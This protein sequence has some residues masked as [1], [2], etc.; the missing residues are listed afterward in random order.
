[1]ERKV[2]WSCRLPSGCSVR[3]TA[4]I[5]RADEDESCILTRFA[6]VGTLLA[7]IIMDWPK[8]WL[9]VPELE[10]YQCKT[11]E[12]IYSRVT[13]NRFKS[14]SHFSRLYTQ[15]VIFFCNSLYLTYRRSNVKQ[16]VIKFLRWN[17][18]WNRLQVCKFEGNED[19]CLLRFGEMYCFHLQSK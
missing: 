15:E 2:C 4:L 17:I 16:R 8:I 19:R 9:C 7:L 6:S 12:I 1:M 11:P 5:L 13:W 3:S 14:N 18:F 10:G